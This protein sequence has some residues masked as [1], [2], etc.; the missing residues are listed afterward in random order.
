MDGYM[1]TNTYAHYGKKLL[2]DT[3]WTLI[4]GEQD[5]CCSGSRSAEYRLSALIS[6]LFYRKLSKNVNLYLYYLVG[7]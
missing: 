4:V 2:G 6:V 1:N 7:K 3:Q 5:V